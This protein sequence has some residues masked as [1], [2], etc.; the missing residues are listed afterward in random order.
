MAE[1]KKETIYIDVDDEITS[2]IEKLQS[3]KNKIIALVLPKRAAVLQSTVNMRLLK[4]AAQEDKKSVVLITS[5][6]ALLPLAGVVGLHVAKTLQS[7]PVIP[8]PPERK[9]TTLTISEDADTDDEGEPVDPRTPI[10]NLIGE[11][12]P[13]A[14][15]E[16]TID[17]DYDETK[18]NADDSKESKTA[19]HNKKLKV[20]NF[21]KFRL[22][23]ILGCFSLVLLIIGSIWAFYIAPKALV[24]LKTDTTTVS[25]V[26]NLTGSPSIKTV[27]KDK[28]I[29]PLVTKELK[30]TET[31]KVATTGQK[32]NG[33]KAGGTMAVYYCPNNNSAEIALPVGSAFSSNGVVFRTTAVV[34]VP[35]SNFTG[36]GV[37]KKDLSQSVAVSADIA[38]D[39]YNF[40]SRA[41]GNVH[42]SDVTGLGS[43]MTGGTSKLVKA[44]GQSDLDVTRQQLLEKTRSAAMA[45]LNNQLTDAACVPLSDSIVVSAQ[46]VTSSPNVGDEAEE[47]T[48]TL[49]VT[50]AMAGVAQSDLKQLIEADVNQKI[51]SSRQQIQDKDSGLSKASVKLSEKK[52]NG[53]LPFEIQVQVSA[54]PK[55]DS[56]AVK[57]E[58]I[59]KRKGEAIEAIKA[60]PGVK[61]VSI[62]YSPFWVISTPKKA[63]K[64]TVVFEQAN[65][66][67]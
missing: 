26:L 59:G 21:E 55:L 33:T 17:V 64:I 7:K 28:L 38:G 43:V 25:S 52:P 53:D 11:E 3:S 18:E 8:S 46:S 12:T 65:G 45:E 4:R 57:K 51:D 58:I 1:A 66:S 30:K 42:H 24:T 2:V 35:A 62:Q 67:Q 36:G 32:D 20:P 16:E 63:S 10:G 49:S 5:E 22:W 14:I 29:V 50:Y 31:Q 40:S 48:V 61:E 13:A 34:T 9:T 23:I 19:N 37:C 47:T 6:A 15:E 56:D 54:G 60:R 41:Y 39:K 44:V 27:D